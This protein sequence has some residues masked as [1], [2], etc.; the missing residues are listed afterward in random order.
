MSLSNTKLKYSGFVKDDRESDIGKGTHGLYALW[1][2]R[3]SGVFA[4]N[5]KVYYDR[6]VLMN[7][8]DLVGYWFFTLIF[9]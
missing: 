3:K 4:S 6:K 1:V 7:V 9:Y 5:G 8:M 2:L